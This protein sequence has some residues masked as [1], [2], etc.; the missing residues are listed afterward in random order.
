MTIGPTASTVPFSTAYT[1]R[2]QPLF[3]TASGVAEV[4]V[5]DGFIEESGDLAEGFFKPEPTHIEVYPSYGTEEQVMI[6][7][8]VLEGKAPTVAHAEDSRF[9]NLVRNLSFLESDEVKRTP[10]KIEFA[11]K[12]IQVKTDRDGVFEVAIGGFA[13]LKPG[14]HEVKVSMVGNADYL[15]AEAKGKVVVQ[16]RDDDSFGVLS[17]ID[18][19]IQFSYASNKLK[20]AATL[21][22]GNEATLKP[23]PGM[24]ALYQALETAS[25]GLQDGD[26]AY[27]SGSPMNYAGRIQNF[28]RAEGFPEGPIQLKNMGFRQ[29]EDSPLGQSD[30]KLN[31]LR[32]MFD[33]YPQKSFFL[34]GDSGESDPEIYR[35]IAQ[36]YPERV[37]GI[38]IHNV[39]E[40]SP[41]D[42]RFAGMHVI[43]SGY[44]AAKV[45]QTQ[46]I[47]NDA[48]VETVRRA[49][50]H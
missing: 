16:R 9:A 36:E 46:G 23:V 32:E 34:F 20:A 4:G 1:L 7:G 15:A 14:Y 44:D 48:A 40:S 29:G 5:V 35:Q 28:M 50:E 26:V 47:L 43:A 6:R 25:D 18:D 39:T 3:E 12:T 42:G 10:V 17:D 45:L 31:H 8:R 38:F 21:L 37:Q 24:A 22:L 41:T 11:G 19:T 27:L 33:T 13:G 2:S 30:Y 49:Q